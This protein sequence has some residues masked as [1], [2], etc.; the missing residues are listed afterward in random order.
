VKCDQARPF[1][2]ACRAVGVACEGYSSN[3]RWMQPATLSSASDAK[4]AEIEEGSSN[5]TRRHLYSGQP[6]DVDPF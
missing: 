3:V 2:L 1:C 6:Y 4:A 5:I